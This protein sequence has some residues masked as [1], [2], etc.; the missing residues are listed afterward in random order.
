MNRQS[1]TK[2]QKSKDSALFTP[3]DLLQRK[4]INR[5]DFGASTVDTRSPS[6][7]QI[8]KSGLTGTE[9]H[10][11]HDFS[12]IPVRLNS[13]FPIQAKLKIGQPNDK[14]EQEADRVAEQV[15][16]MPDPRLT[17]SVGDLALANSTNPSSG[18][19]QRACASCSAE[20]KTA[21]DES[22]P[23]EPANLCS[24]CRTQEQ[25]LIQ[26]KQINPLIQTKTT[27]AVTP[28]VT[29][30]ISSGIQSLQGRGQPLSRSERSFFEPRFG[31]DFS[32]VRVHSDTRAANA[33]RS[34]NARAF[35]LGHNV[36]FGAGEY[37]LDSLAGRKLLAH[38]L[39]H[40]LQQKYKKSQSTGIQRIVTVNPNTTATDDILSQFRFMCA[41]VNFGRSGQTITADSSSIA[42]E[43]CKCLSD[44]AGDT[45]RTY[46][47]N[48][49]NVTNSPRRVVL[50]NGTTATI[51][52]P[53]SGPTTSLGANPTIYMPASGGSAIEFG[54]F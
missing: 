1:I 50:H 35:T 31:A 6:G 12:K 54:A 38:E 52:Y 26:T 51:P 21:E 18:S 39:T 42:S 37:S 17:S 27:G 5:T 44:V 15:M 4:T 11:S 30:S 20:Y 48:V 47:I 8:D 24:K 9:S 2:T 14:Y 10:F 45:E 23:I 25:E 43:S 7:Q 33:A 22:R 28:D 16:R 53:S 19:I 3:T 46:T 29:P 32:G 34:V 40:V 36:V 41:D 49:D 13:S